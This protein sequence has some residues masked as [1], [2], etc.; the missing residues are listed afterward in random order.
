MPIVVAWLRSINLA[1]EVPVQPVEFTV[2]AAAIAVALEDFPLGVFTRQ[3]RR[4]AQQ[5]FKY[6]PGSA[7]VATFLGSDAGRLKST[8]RALRIIVS[9][10]PPPPLEPEPT[11]E[12]RLAVQ[13]ARQAVVDEFHRKLREAGL[14]AGYGKMRVSSS[15]DPDETPQNA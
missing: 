13:A 2:R 6:F 1:S 14:H 10:P 15:H 3:T 9:L 4:M 5:Q 11:P 8:L 7:T 12:E